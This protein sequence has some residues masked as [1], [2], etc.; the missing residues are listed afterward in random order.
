MAL[1][2]TRVWMG[3]QEDRAFDWSEEEQDVFDPAAFK[4]EKAARQASE[5]VF[6]ADRFA[7]ARAW[8][9]WV[10]VGG[11]GVCW[12]WNGWAGAVGGRVGGARGVCGRWSDPR[13][14]LRLAWQAIRATRRGLAWL[15][16]R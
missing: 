10:G 2:L 15:G 1:R 12:L 16:R 7:E 9:R 5:D 3:C 13:R 6:A 14:C 4:A 11:A 8:G